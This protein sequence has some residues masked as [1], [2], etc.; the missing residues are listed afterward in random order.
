MSVLVARHGRAEVVFDACL[1]DA[2]RA[3]ACLDGHFISSFLR[4]YTAPPGVG[5]SVNS[6]VGKGIIA[7]ISKRLGHGLGSGLAL[8]C[9]TGNA[10]ADNPAPIKALPLKAAAS[11]FLASLLDLGGLPARERD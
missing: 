1:A 10:E 2:V 8:V 11:G 7:H 5:G 3:P 4:G 6:A 9:L